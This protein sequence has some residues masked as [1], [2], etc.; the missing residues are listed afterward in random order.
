MSSCL[1]PAQNVFVPF[2]VPL[3]S[4]ASPVLAC[5]QHSFSTPQFW[6]QPPSIAASWPS[7]EVLPH[8]HCITVMILR[9]IHESWEEERDHPLNL[10]PKA[11]PEL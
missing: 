5:R 7:S 2:A 4:V 9:Q 10:P 1:Q 6:L 3:N 11:E 8:K